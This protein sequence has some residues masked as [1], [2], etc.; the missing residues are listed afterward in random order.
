M[1]P[2]PDGR[3]MPHEACVFGLLLSAAGLCLLALYSS[4][5]AALLA[6][7][8]VVIYLAVYTPLK[9]RSPIATLVL[10]INSR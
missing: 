6:L 4:W 9:R 1:R 3:L 7:A 8:T 5:L 10:V 2:L